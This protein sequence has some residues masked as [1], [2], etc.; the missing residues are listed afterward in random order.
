MKVK[1]THEDLIIKDVCS[2]LSDKLEVKEVIHEYSGNKA[3]EFKINEDSVVISEQDVQDLI[4]KL[5]MFLRQ[6]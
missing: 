5:S 1:D 6:H 3:I 2:L 4:E